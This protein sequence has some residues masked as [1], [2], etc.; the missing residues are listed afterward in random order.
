MASSPFYIAL[1]NNSSTVG[2]LTATYPGPGAWIYLAQ[3]GQPNQQW[4]QGSD[5]GLYLA[6]P[7]QTNVCLDVPFQPT[8]TGHQ[9]LT[10]NIQI[11]GRLT[12]VWSLPGINATATTISNV[13]MGLNIPGSSWNL[14]DNNQL[15]NGQIQVWAN[16]GHTWQLTPTQS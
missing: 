12:Q 5:N 7:G 8:G 15:A 4:I 14:D 10:L 11:P 1:I 16:S 6:N 2:Y 3:S 9:W 13:G